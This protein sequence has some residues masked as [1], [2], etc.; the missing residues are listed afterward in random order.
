M[1]DFMSEWKAENQKLMFSLSIKVIWNLL[2]DTNFIFNILDLHKDHF[3]W[4]HIVC[5]IWSRDLKVW[6]LSKWYEN[7]I[8]TIAFLE[9][10]L[11]WMWETWCTSKSESLI[12]KDLKLW[13]IQTSSS[14]PK[15]GTWYYSYLQFK[16]RITCLFKPGQYA[17]VI[18][19]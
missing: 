16:N 15:C 11:S 18:V 5:L 4:Y 13:W 2:W 14:K 12:S 19:S 10:Q 3:L 9:I 6:P 17:I 1:Y 8:K 7:M